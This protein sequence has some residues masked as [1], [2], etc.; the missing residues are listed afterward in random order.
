MTRETDKK[1][2]LA[3]LDNL[4]EKPACLSEEYATVVKDFWYRLED[5]VP[6]LRAPCAGPGDDLRFQFVWSCKRYYINFDIS[7]D[8]SFGWV[9]VDRETE[10]VLGSEDED[11]LMELTDE[12][13]S[14]LTKVNKGD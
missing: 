4:T 10:E 6:D 2:W 3:Y 5:Q 12:I 7:A 8:R 13:V 14:C 11:T 1:A 9:F